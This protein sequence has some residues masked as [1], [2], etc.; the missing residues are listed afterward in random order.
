MPF[1]LGRSLLALAGVER[2]LRRRREAREALARAE[3]CFGGLGA[4]TWLRRVDAERARISGRAPR[5]GS[6]TPGEQ[7]IVA[8]VVEGK[9]NEEDRGR[10]LLFAQH[11]RIPPPFGLPTLGV[12]SPRRADR[13]H[14]EGR[15]IRRPVT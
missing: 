14:A 3:D 6:L 13:P 9:S 5:S 12:R 1:E 15:R 11:G 8:L 2:R 7:Q 4:R 10:A